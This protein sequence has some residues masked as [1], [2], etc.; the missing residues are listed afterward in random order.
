VCLCATK[1]LKCGICKESS[2]TSSRSLWSVTYFEIILLIC[3]HYIKCFCHPEWSQHKILTNSPFS[4]SGTKKILDRF[5][6]TFLVQNSKTKNTPPF[7]LKRTKG[8]QSIRENHNLKISR[9][10]NLSHFGF[11]LLKS[12][13]HRLKIFSHLSLLARNWSSAERNP[14]DKWSARW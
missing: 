12:G 9:F 8:K 3:N 7:C 10:L 14:L 5:G 11:L 6:N 2:W 4:H 1:Y 13:N